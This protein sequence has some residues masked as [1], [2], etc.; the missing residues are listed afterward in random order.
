MIERRKTS[1]GKGQPLPVDFTKMVQEVFTNHFSDGLK[2]LAKLKSPTKFQASAEVFP[3]E[4]ILAVSLVTEKALAST[5][6]YASSDFDPKASSP[7]LEDLLSLCIDAVANVMQKVFDPTDKE[8]MELLADNSLASFKDIPFKW[9]QME[10]EK[11][12]L[13]VRVDKANLGLDQMADDWL[14]KNDP[15]SLIEDA[16]FEETREKEISKHFVFPPG[17]PRKKH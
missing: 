9:A 6:F 16:E 4:V 10:V 3:D 14:A 15:D 1:A 13:Y 8:K 7:K 5:T 17:D 2:A 12:T 11:K